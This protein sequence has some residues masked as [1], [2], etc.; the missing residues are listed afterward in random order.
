M[1]SKIIPK[2]PY[3]PI[4]IMLLFFRKDRVEDRTFSELEKLSVLRPATDCLLPI[5]SDQEDT[6]HALDHSEICRDTINLE[7]YVTCGTK[8]DVAFWVRLGGPPPRIA[9]GFD[10][11]VLHDYSYDFFHPGLFEKFVFR[12]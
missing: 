8:F 3:P 7:G 2:R 6:F 10:N 9:R 4:K 1:A 12:I 11:T 5:P